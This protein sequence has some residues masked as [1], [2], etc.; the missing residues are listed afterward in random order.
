MFHRG[1]AVIEQ[2]QFAKGDIVLR[3]GEPGDYVVKLL[4]GQ[5]EV[6]RG[7]GERSVVLG[8]CG[9][10]EFVG[11][12]SVLE[13]RSRSATVRAIEA[14]TAERVERDD[15]LRLISESQEQAHRVIMRLSERL[16][17][18]DQLLADAASS[19]V[20]SRGAPSA[21]R[22]APQ[23]GRAALRLTLLPGSERIAA[24]LPP[25]GVVIASPPFLVGRRPTPHEDPP[26]VEVDLALPDAKPYRLSR[27]HFAIEP[28]GDNYVVRD[29]S[30]HL[31]TLVNG[32]ALGDHF[33]HDR[34]LLD[35]GEN[36]I[37]AGGVEA[38]FSFVLRIEETD[39]A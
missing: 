16:R 6:V 14:V 24:H 33:L 25:E 30:S 10:G 9:P 1:D 17:L 27:L 7:L 36:S 3:E 2:L 35:I 32:E 19:S 26:A 28:A 37:V 18:T 5:V 4:S 15:F 34:K 23:Q 8:I 29:L 11:E 38:D 31:G 12:M 39:K 22:P 21:A 13:G 20:R